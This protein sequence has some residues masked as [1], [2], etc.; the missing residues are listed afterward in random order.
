MARSHIHEFYITYADLHRQILSKEMK[1]VG[2]SLAVSKNFFRQQNFVYYIEKS[3][4]HYFWK[5]FLLVIQSHS[6]PWRA[7]KYQH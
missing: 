2:F 3:F 6:D 5:E 7:Y 4:Y 1:M